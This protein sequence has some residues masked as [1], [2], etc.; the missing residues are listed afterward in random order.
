MSVYP[1]IFEPIFKE[2][3][4]GGRKLET[5]LNKPLP[6]GVAIGESWELADL[7]HDQSV[8]AN[9]PRKGDTLGKLVAEFGRALTG[10]VPLFEGRFPLLIKF[11]DATDTLSVQVHP[12]KAMAER[13]GGHVRVKNEAWYILAADPGGFIY[14]G[15]KPGVTA[16]SFRE[17]IENGQ[18]VDQLERLTV[19]AG[20]CYYLPSGTVHALGAGVTV[21]E[22]QTPSAVTYRVY[23]W[24]RIEASTMLPRALHIDEAMSCMQF[25]AQSFDQE[26]QCP[27]ESG[28]PRALSLLR[29][30]SF[31]M[32]LA[33]LRGGQTC[34][35]RNPAFVIWIVL[36][37][38]GRITYDGPGEAVRF[39]A[40]DTV[41]LP[42]DLSNGQVEA[43]E[44]CQWLD[45]SVPISV[46]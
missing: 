11:L 15:V 2:K 33:R 31:V 5:A 20:D 44:D 28:I 38:H 9:G 6:A 10:P 26:R 30:E 13:L 24:G 37:G 19:Q 3:I 43:I 21:A 45:V 27:S 23:D 7:E 8:V 46:V 25:G 41:L 39:R 17:A 4:W 1:L 42:A 29:S 18:V 34:P 32:D 36:G 22:V 12:D 40:G 16:E 14:R 35:L